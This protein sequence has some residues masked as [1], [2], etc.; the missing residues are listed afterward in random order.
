MNGVLGGVLNL[1]IKLAS[2]RVLNGIWQIHPPFHKRL[3]VCYDYG[4]H[5]PHALIAN[6]IARHILKTQGGQHTVQG[7]NELCSKMD[8]ARASL[9]KEP[10]H[11]V[12]TIISGTKL[13]Q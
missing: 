10:N 8:T 6:Q 11:L 4:K 7:L 1:M 12:K 2:L 9:K 5:I 13:P 3:S